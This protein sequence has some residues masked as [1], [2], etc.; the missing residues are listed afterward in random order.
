MDLNKVFAGVNLRKQFEEASKKGNDEIGDAMPTEGENKIGK[1]DSWADVWIK[2]RCHGW[3]RRVSDHRGGEFVY[4]KPNKIMATGKKGVDY[5]ICE[6]DFQKH[7]I[8][9]GGWEA[10]GEKRVEQMLMSAV[11]NA[12]LLSETTKRIV[13]PGFQRFV[14]VASRPNIVAAILRLPQEKRTEVSKVLSK[15][16]LVADFNIPEGALER[17]MT[18]TVDETSESFWDQKQNEVKDNTFDP[19]SDLA[20]VRYLNGEDISTDHSC[21]SQENDGFFGRLIQELWVEPKGLRQKVPNMKQ[22]KM[23]MDYVAEKERRKVEERFTSFVAT[24]ADEDSSTE[25]HDSE[26]TSKSFVA[27]QDT[28]NMVPGSVAEVSRVHSKCQCSL[29]GSF[30]DEG[31]SCELSAWCIRIVPDHKGAIKEGMRSVEVT[32]ETMPIPRL[33]RMLTT[34]GYEVVIAA[35]NCKSRAEMRTA[36]IPFHWHTAYLKKHSLM[37]V[38]A[39]TGEK[40]MLE[41]VDRAGR[42]HPITQDWI[43]T[44]ELGISKV[45]LPEEWVK[46]MMDRVEKGITAWKAITEGAKKRRRKGSDMELSWG[47]PAM[48][49]KLRQNTGE[50]SCY[51]DA[52]ATALEIWGRMDGRPEIVACG[53]KIHKEGKL[54]AAEAADSQTGRTTALI[55]S[56]V[57][58]WGYRFDL[59]QD[60]DP[61]LDH[62]NYPVV[63]RLISSS[64]YPHCVAIFGNYILDPTEPRAIKLGEDNLNTICGGE[65]KYLGIAWA[66]GFRPFQQTVEEAKAWRLGNRCIPALPPDFCS[67]AT[68]FVHKCACRDGS[69]LVLAAAAALH[70]HRLVNVSRKLQS[71]ALE[72]KEEVSARPRMWLRDRLTQLLAGIKTMKMGCHSLDKNWDPFGDNKVSRDMIVAEVRGHRHLYV[73]FVNGRMMTPSHPQWVEA[74]EQNMKFFTDEDYKGIQWAMAFGGEPVDM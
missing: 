28:W 47:R 49:L 9:T 41:G 56:I 31:C 34:G 27:Y 24:P 45:R 19:G 33:R 55:S 53:H 15:M 63:V 36:V 37:K 12:Q 26:T 38:R 68:G 43:G 10:P 21:M 71:G 66:R 61:L 57:G 69:A 3:H 2:L 65:G 46:D 74:T 16:R 11:V 13:R 73:S 40:T 42:I 5:F 32:K 70:K 4:M 60:Y 39:A 8:R 50:H 7:V 30:G 64:A 20:L 6:A 67:R 58:D 29:E 22:K 52:A 35:L 14:R 23:W 48:R 72:D 59:L 51:S 17:A 1:D 25:S 62:M 18:M 54:M 44:A